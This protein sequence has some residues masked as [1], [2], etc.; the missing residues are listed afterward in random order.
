MLYWNLE[1]LA[2][3]ELGELHCSTGHK[4]EIFCWLENVWDQISTHV[5]LYYWWDHKQ[6]LKDLNVKPRMNRYILY[7]WRIR[8]GSRVSNATN[9]LRLKRMLKKFPDNLHRF[10][11]RSVNCPCFC[12]HQKTSPFSTSRI[13]V[14]IPSTPHP[15]C[16]GIKQSRYPFAV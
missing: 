2:T 1:K 9:L 13:F 12:S 10:K 7:T 16:N 8:K 11:S 6:F 15:L 3:A 14:N 5:L 4:L